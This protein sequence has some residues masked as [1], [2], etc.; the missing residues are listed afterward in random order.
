MK[1]MKQILA[2]VIMLCMSLFAYSQDITSPNTSHVKTHDSLRV[3]KHSPTAAILYSIIPGGGQIY[4]RKY[5]K[6]P[7]IYTML[8]A[9][10]YFLTMYASDMMLYRREFINRRDGNI[11]QLV[12]GLAEYP[13]ENILAMKQEA[14][15]NMEICIAATAI[16]YT[17]NFIDAMVDAHLYY[18]DVSDD[19]AIRWSPSV[20]SNPINTKPSYGVSLV[21]SFK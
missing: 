12:P 7:I 11:D 14:Q 10:S 9:S 15:R 3:A 21:L 8:G 13:D 1:N 16:I 4:N 5:W 2:I 18:F 19:L 17:L 6:V 20:F